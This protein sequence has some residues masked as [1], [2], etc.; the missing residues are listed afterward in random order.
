MKHTKT[1][2]SF[3]LALA[4]LGGFVACNT[5]QQGV[6]VKSLAS[7][8]DAANTAYT[9]YMGLVLDK[10]VATNG[11]PAVAE[12]Y[13]IYQ[14]AFGLAVVAVTSSTNSPVPQSVYDAAAKLTQIIADAKQLKGTK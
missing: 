8:H 9:A 14:T 1:Y 2:L 6:A 11:V 4:I 5:T 13:R 7:T 12:A 3:V 10:K